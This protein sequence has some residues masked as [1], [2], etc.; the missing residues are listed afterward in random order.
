M[1]KILE[2]LLISSTWIWHISYPDKLSERSCWFGTSF[3]T[4]D[5]AGFLD[6]VE[7]ILIVAVTFLSLVRILKDDRAA[8]GADAWQ[9]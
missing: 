3:I 6:C 2:S 5:L 1:Y 9:I 7:D 8:N 4:E